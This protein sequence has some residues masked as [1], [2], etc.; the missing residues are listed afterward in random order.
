M[1]A[2]QNNRTAI[3]EYLFS[4]GFPIDTLRWDMPFVVMA[5]GENMVAMAETLVRCGA[6]LHQR[7]P[8]RVHSVLFRATDATIGLRVQCAAVGH[9]QQR[10]R[11]QKR[12]SRQRSRRALFH[13][14]LL[15]IIGGHAHVT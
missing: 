4:R 5:V 1:L 3:M 10:P 15:W 8:E 13:H 2:F 14:V 7:P 11:L 9:Q 12:R 6:N